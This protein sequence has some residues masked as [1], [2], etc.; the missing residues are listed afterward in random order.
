ME[1]LLGERQCNAREG[2]IIV[3][4]RYF[5]KKEQNLSD[6]WKSQNF[7]EPMNV[8]L[9]I[10]GELLYSS[11]RLVQ[12]MDLAGARCDEDAAFPTSLNPALT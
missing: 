1:E 6:F 11:R 10:S 7:S 4:L 2:F 12:D 8:C 3:S 9:V 5:C